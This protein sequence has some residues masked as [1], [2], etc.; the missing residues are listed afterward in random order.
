MNLA[1]SKMTIGLVAEIN[2]VIIGA[3]WVRCIKAFG[4]IDDTILEFAILVYPQYRKRGIGTELMK[5]MI[6]YLKIKGYS[7]ASLAVQ[8]ANSAVKMYKKAGFE[9]KDENDEEYIMLYS[10]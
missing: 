9:I 5:E 1:P 7:K 10:F 8:K 4:Y 2:G 6:K 3:V